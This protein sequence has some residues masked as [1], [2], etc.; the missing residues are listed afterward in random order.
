MSTS[1]LSTMAAV[2][3]SAVTMSDR[4]SANVRLAFNWAQMKNT[5]KVGYIAMQTILQ[6][7]FYEEI[8]M[9]LEAKAGVAVLFEIII[10][11]HGRIPGRI[12]DR[13]PEK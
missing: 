13:I 12:H 10:V 9:F 5:A 6:M 11:F 8:L 4:I 7:W 2:N 1:A 3:T